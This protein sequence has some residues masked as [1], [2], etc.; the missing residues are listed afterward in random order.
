MLAII[1][2]CYNASSSI[3]RLLRSISD[4]TNQ[5]FLHIVIDGASTDETVKILQKFEYQDCNNTTLNY[6][7][8]YLSESDLGIYDA[9]NKGLT[10]AG[11]RSVIFI[12]SD[13]YL[14][15]NNSVKIIYQKIVLDANVVHTF[16]IMYKKFDK[17]YKSVPVSLFWEDLVWDGSL[18]RCP[19]ISTVYPASTC[20][21][22]L[23]YKL[24][25]DY[26]Y[27]IRM[28]QRFGVCAHSAAISV[29]VR[30]EDQLSNRYREVALKES[31][32]ISK[33]YYFPLISFGMAV[34]LARWYIINV[35]ERIKAWWVN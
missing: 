34:R 11:K 24:A 25:S 1:T 31:Q 30:S 35:S 32:E 26:D 5:N 6:K 23:D 27:T 28:I 2:V 15:N 13:D 22:K 8:V 9:M 7:R 10:L 12:N 16:S 21:Y 19:H 18:R 17:S 3:E 20:F 33:H 14:Y 29:M 4:Q